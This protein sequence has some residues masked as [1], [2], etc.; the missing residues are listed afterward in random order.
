MSICSVHLWLVLVCGLAPVSTAM[1]QG[2]IVYY[3]PPQPLSPL[4]GSALDLNGDGQME[5][6]FYDASYGP[7][8]YW[9][10]DA[11]GVGSASLLVIP[12]LGADGGSHLAPMTAGF[13]IGNSG[14]P[15][16]LWAAQDAPNAHGD[17]LLLGSYSP[18]VVGGGLVPVGFFYGTTAF[19]GI[20]FQIESDWHYGWVRVRGGT[21]GP[22]D[23]GQEF[24]LNPPAWVVDWG[25]ELR[26]DTPILA[27][28][29][30]EPSTWAL[31]GTGGLLLWW[32]GRRKQ[33][34]RKG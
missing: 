21:A 30:P 32:Y 28:A 3:Q 31:L 13:L 6:R 24:Y 4:L 20:Q 16:L 29:V 15:S 23:D 9:A 14:D 26:P 8:N 33:R 1:A 22:S 10:T 11:S 34:G 12:N 7:A 5:L 18:E 2:T 19:I 27:G 17:A 25:Y